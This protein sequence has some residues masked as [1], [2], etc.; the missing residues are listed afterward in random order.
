MSRSLLK[1]EEWDKTISHNI[2]FD[3]FVIIENVPSGLSYEM[4]PVLGI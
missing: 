2:S 3:N 1:L 4:K